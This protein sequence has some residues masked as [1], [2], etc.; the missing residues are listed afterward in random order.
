MAGVL[1]GYRNLVDTATITFGSE[2]TG[3]EA[4]NVAVKQPGIRYRCADPTV[5]ASPVADNAHLIF[6]LGSAQSVS[7]VA[8]ISTNLTAD[9]GQWRVAAHASN[10]WGS[11]TYNSGAQNFY[12]ESGLTDW[13]WLSSYEYY[14]SAKS[15][16]WWRIDF[17][18]AAVA[19]GFIECGR[20]FIGQPLELTY[21]IKDGEFQIHWD[22][23]RVSVDTVGGQTYTSR[24]PRSRMVEFAPGI[25]TTAEAWADVMEIGRLAGVSDDIIFIKDKN[26]SNYQHSQFLQG[27]F[28]SVPKISSVVVDTYYQTGFKIR[29]L[30]P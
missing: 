27:E 12:L 2:V 28:V 29:E 9:V 5:S 3:F 16:R 20:V 22:Q 4:A 8:A 30:R 26:A 1:I 21:D 24:T 15:F 25:L 11:P 17:L 19:E 23:T 7:L 13:D 14:S 6:D 18:D 10:S